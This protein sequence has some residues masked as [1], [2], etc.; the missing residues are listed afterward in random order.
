MQLLN[1]WLILSLSLL[2]HLTVCSSQNE[3]I[4]NLN[5]KFNRLNRKANGLQRDVNGLQED[6]D[7]IWTAVSYQGNNKTE[8]DNQNSVEILKQV[9][10]MKELKVNAKN[11]F[12][13]E[14]AFIRK[15]LKEIQT[16]QL[17]HEAITSDDIAEM[18]VWLLDLEQQQ[19]QSLEEKFLNFTTKIEMDDR[20]LLEKTQNI[21]NNCEAKLEEYKLEN[22]ALNDKL[23]SS[24][25]KY[26]TDA[27]AHVKQEFFENLQEAFTCKD[28]WK[29]F[30]KSCYLFISTMM[31]WNDSQKFCNKKG[32]HLVEL[33]DMEEIDFLV[34]NYTAKYPVWIGGTDQESEG[35]FVWQTSNKTIS[36]DY[37]APDEPNDKEGNEDCAQLYFYS[38]DLFGKLNDSN[39][40]R[41]RE[42]ICE[43][44]I[45]IN[46]NAV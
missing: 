32:A 44:K 22:K 9:A 26:V 6:V 20:I 12:K 17:D 36:S 7:E 34:H 1:K 16:S 43:K 10:E 45:Y 30:D 3:A 24:M 14:K 25:Q 39:C 27:V 41:E 8:P 18:K 21:E 33:E 37:F 19:R 28:P 11:G 31:T 35:T 15:I 2:W 13:N 4:H 38:G 40:K 5:Q 29:Y 46:L 23:K 42:F